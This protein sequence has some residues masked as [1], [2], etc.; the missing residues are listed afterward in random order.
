MVRGNQAGVGHAEKIHSF[1]F[2]S[3]K[4]IFHGGSGDEEGKKN[5]TITQLHLFGPQEIAI[6]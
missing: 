3:A 5:N 2:V 1:L 4:C 6:S